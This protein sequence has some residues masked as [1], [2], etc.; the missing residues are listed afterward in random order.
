MRSRI[1]YPLLPDPNYW[2]YP[3]VTSI[4][5]IGAKKQ[6]KNLHGTLTW[7]KTWLIANA[8][9]MLYRIFGGNFHP[10]LPPPRGVMALSA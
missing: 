10:P 3:Y 4:T 6:Q 1:N 2:R 7:M 8:K 5:N 9:G